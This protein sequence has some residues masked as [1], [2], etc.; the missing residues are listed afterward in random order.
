MLWPTKHDIAIIAFVAVFGYFMY[1]LGYWHLL[2]GG[3]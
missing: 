2:G 3:F 1:T